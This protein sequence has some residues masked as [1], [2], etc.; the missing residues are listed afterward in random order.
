MII[1]H[2]KFLLIIGL[3]LAGCSTEDN[4][5]NPSTDLAGSWDTR[6]RDNGNVCG[7]D[8]KI[9]TDQR[10]ECHVWWKKIDYA[11]Y[12]A[13]NYGGKITLSG[14]NVEILDTANA[15]VYIGK[16]SMS[17]KDR[18]DI[19]GDLAYLTICFEQLDRIK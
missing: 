18:I 7:A 12:C 2:C 1:K 14:D 5:G 8:L 11:D 13:E 3:F 4:S 19:S 17:S 10:F 16:I 6:Q 15:K 9:F